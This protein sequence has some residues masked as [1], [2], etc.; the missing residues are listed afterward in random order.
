MKNVTRRT[1]LITGSSSGIGKAAALYF[2]KKGWNVVATMRDPSHGSTLA[3]LENVLCLPLDVTKPVTIAEAF[4]STHSKF[5]AVQA[6]VN[7]AG[8]AV[9]GVF[10]SISRD[11]IH[12]QFETNVFGLMDVAAAAI[13]HFRD[14]GEGTLINV[15]SM[16]GRITFPICSAYH[17][18]K[19]AV[20]GYTESL[21]YEL[22]PLGIKVRLVEP[23]VIKTDFYN[24][25]MDSPDISQVAEPYRNYLK[26]VSPRLLEAGEKG[27]SPEVA[28]RVIYR[29]ATD[30][31]WKLR[32]PA[33]ADARVLLALR[34]LL[35]ERWF[36]RLVR[37]A[38][39]G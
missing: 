32:Y 14:R 1:A 2:Q 37:A 5:G 16:G 6:V 38:A 22:Q 29:A 8:Y 20:E 10:E 12:K 31:G 13:A 21:R 33:G 35:P 15:S 24:R 11:Q 9:T 26:V 39:G 3:N 25:S 17:A 28:A 27:A 23:G 34:G 36:L 7:N 19:W 4:R 30:R 18:T